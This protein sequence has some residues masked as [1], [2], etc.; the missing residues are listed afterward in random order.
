MILT[1]IGPKRK[2]D[3]DVGFKRREF[4]AT[5][6]LETEGKIGSSLNHFTIDYSANMH[7]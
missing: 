6:S 2:G 4:S 3:M 7:G 5:R 1:A